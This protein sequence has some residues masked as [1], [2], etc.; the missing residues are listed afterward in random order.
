MTLHDKI[1]GLHI[2]GTIFLWGGAILALLL[3]KSALK[4]PVNERKILGRL[5]IFSQWLIPLGAIA[6]SLS[7]IGLINEG[8]GWYLGWLD[9]SIITTLLIIPVII[10]R[11]NTSL[12]GLTDEKSPLSKQGNVLPATLKAHFNQIFALLFL[13][14][15]LMLMKPGTPMAVLL[16]AGTFAISWILQPKH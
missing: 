4:K 10:F 1:Y 8:W 6:L 11:L 12:S 3:A 2:L 5:A 13:G 14:T 16:A 7:G 9:I 15:L